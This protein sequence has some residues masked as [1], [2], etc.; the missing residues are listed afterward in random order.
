M[1]REFDAIFC[2]VGGRNDLSD[3]TLAETLR[4]LNGT[5]RTSTTGPVHLGV[6]GYDDDPRELWEIPE[7]RDY[8]RRLILG[9]DLEVKSRLDPLSR[10]LGSVC[11]GMLR[12]I[13]K[14]P[15]TGNTRFERTS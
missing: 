15:V 2:V 7:V 14:D 3:S 9:L 11:C 4:H 1:M 5:V 12:P 6:D 8:I 10:I 13:G